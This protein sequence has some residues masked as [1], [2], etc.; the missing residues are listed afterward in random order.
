M[1][2]VPT[3][4][5]GPRSTARAVLR[6]GFWFDG[7]ACWATRASSG[8]R[9]SLRPR[10]SPARYSAWAE[11]WTASV[12]VKPAL[13]GASV[14]LATWVCK[15]S[16]RR[17]TRASLSRRASAC[18]VKLTGAQ[19]VSAWL[20]VASSGTEPRT[21]E[22]TVSIRMLPPRGVEELTWE[23]QRSH[24]RAVTRRVG[25]W[26]CSARSAS[27]GTGACTTSTPASSARTS[28]TGCWCPPTTGPRW[29]SASGRR[30]GS[31][32]TPTASPGS[33]GLA[34]DDDLRRDELMRKRKAE[35]QVA[36]KR[37]IREHDL[38]MKVVAVDH[39]PGDPRSDGSAPV[40]APRSTSP[41]RTGST[42]GRWSATWARPCTAGS[43]CA[44]SPPA[45]RR[46]CRAAS[47]PAAGTCAAPRSSPTSSRSPSGW[48]RTR[49]CR[50]TRC[51]SPARAAG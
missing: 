2:P 47:A 16:E 46:G 37:L 21:T 45:T 31:T 14:R 26:A 25:R 5:T 15:P 36:A 23:C 51:G 43:S 18:A 12:V 17:S 48:P 7:G 24:P 20:G 30:S 39:V 9:G 3:L 6:A 4:P 33:L 1:E 8:P 29:P 28:A 42:S 35:A 49:T 11:P 13:A 27:T 34:G 50:S 40:R 19:V 44:S 41:R 38:P 32:R 22:T 10:T